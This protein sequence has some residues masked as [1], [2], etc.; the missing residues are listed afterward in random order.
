MAA[1]GHLGVVGVGCGTPTKARSWWLSPVKNVVIG[2][3]VKAVSIYL[4]F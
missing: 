4:N 3:V 2:L 1:A